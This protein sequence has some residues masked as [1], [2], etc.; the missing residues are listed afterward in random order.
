MK[1]IQTIL[2]FCLWV[3]LL[4]AQSGIPTPLSPCATEM[5]EALQRLVSNEPTVCVLGETKTFA[6]FGAM[7]TDCFGAIEKPGTV[8]FTMFYYP[9]ATSV[10]VIWGNTKS[11][12]DNY[13][14]CA[15]NPIVFEAPDA[16][17][18]HLYELCFLP[19]TDYQN[20]TLNR[21]EWESI[22]KLQTFKIQ[23]IARISNFEVEASNSLLAQSETA[24]Y[25]RVYSS[26]G[27][28]CNVTLKNEQVIA[29]YVFSNYDNAGTI[30]WKGLPKT[31]PITI[32]GFITMRL[33][34]PGA[35]YAKD[36]Y[37]QKRG[38]N[39]ILEGDIVVADDLPKPRAVGIK[40]PDLR[41]PQGNIPV[42]IDRSV[43]DNNMQKVVET[44]LNRLNDSTELCYVLKTR[45]DQKDYVNIQVLTLPPLPG[46]PANAPLPFAG[47]SRVGRQGG[48]QALTLALEA[49]VT[50]TMH[51][52][53]HA[54]GLYHEQS[55]S[56]RSFYINL[57]E[58]NMTD[59]G[60]GNYQIMP[61]EVSGTYNYCSIMHY[62][63]FAFSKDL[64]IPVI[65]CKAFSPL[66]GANVPQSCPPCMGQRDSLTIGDIRG[67]DRI[68]QEIS[69]FPCRNKISIAPAEQTEWR[70]CQKCQSMFY[71]GYQ[72]K[73]V[74]SAGGSHLAVGRNF[75]LP[76]NGPENPYAQ[77]EWRFCDQCYNMFYDG[78]PDKGACAAA[79]KETT[80]G[81]HEAAGFNFLML[82]DIPNFQADWRFC[83]K[84]SMIFFNGN[85]N[86]GVCT[87]GGAH[88]AAGLSF[89]LVADLITKV[90]GFQNFQPNWRTCNKCAVLFYDG[91]PQK[92][93]CAKGG[94]HRA[95][96]ANLAVPHS[97]AET[98][99]AQANWRYCR[100]CQAMFFDGYPQK[101]ACPGAAKVVKPGGHHAQGHNFVLT[102]D[103]QNR[104]AFRSYQQQWR[105]CGK[106]K[107][108]FYDGFP[109]MKGNCTAGGGH[110]AQG[111]NFALNNK[112]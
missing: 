84:C 19:V 2:L 48:K 21:K 65:E 108:L 82:H 56:D 63:A 91:Y 35:N 23:D 29:C 45:D 51:E 13:R 59:L 49:T 47:E 105:F 26:K 12:Y 10:R 14:V 79:P 50:N 4:Q 69:R 57:R 11:V 61:G 88:L 55:R 71:N 67:I 46:I 43:Y 6:T 111:Y 52:L 102:H 98:N 97:S 32:P 62:G 90:P 27:I 54:A 25:E 78:Y 16:A 33:Q 76:Y 66:P 95:S 80:F 68:Y 24:D 77:K 17:Q 3:T 1:K 38:E 41:W 60:K 70:S 20:T 18:N 101:G 28:R 72:K 5:A 8:S 58:S 93:T 36:Y 87:K 37:V 22:K 86:K 39:Y 106:C 94:A 42:L 92:G 83:S 73:G 30:Q 7:A 64:S 96:G 40:D 34:L 104:P 85:A 112:P 74:C 75:S 103:I 100:K 53:L 15:P 81:E 99:T 107:S 9:G 44:A 109:A 89:A 110:T 31:A